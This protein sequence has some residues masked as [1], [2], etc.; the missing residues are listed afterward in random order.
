MKALAAPA[1]LAPVTAMAATVG[2]WVPFEPSHD[3][4]AGQPQ[5]LLALHCDGMND[6][7]NLQ[8]VGDYWEGSATVQGK[9]REV[10]VFDNGALWIGHRP[11][12]PPKQAALTGICGKGSRDIG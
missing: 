6:V 12:T 10:Y 4:I 8:Q 7:K 9:P 3:A 2:G 11:V 5:A 1:L